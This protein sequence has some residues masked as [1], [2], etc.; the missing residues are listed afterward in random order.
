MLRL[1]N[2]IW[3]AENNGEEAVN[4]Y[5]ETFNSAPG[6]YHK[7]E[8]GDITKS[9]KASEEISGIPAGSVMTAECKL[10]GANFMFLNGGPVEQFKL[11]GGVSFIVE[12]ETQEEIDHFWEKLSAVPEVEQCGWCTDKFG[13]TW[14]ITPRILDELMKDSSKADRVTEVFMPMKKLNLEAIRKAG[15]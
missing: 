14:Q 11:T 7:G 5:I 9:P 6:E 1:I 8:M 4:Y 12:C 2:C 3:F 13:V 15:E 10:D